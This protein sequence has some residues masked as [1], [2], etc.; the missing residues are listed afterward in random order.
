M[1]RAWYVVGIRW[2]QPPPGELGGERV[3]RANTGT[4]IAG[5]W[6]QRARTFF[7]SLVI[8]TCSDGRRKTRPTC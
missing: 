8:V 7:T 2:K 3:A 4:K 5:Q 1:L 6:G